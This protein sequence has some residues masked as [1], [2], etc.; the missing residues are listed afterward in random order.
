VGT[1]EAYPNRDSLSY[2][3]SFGL[4]DVRTMIRGT[5][6]YPGWSETWARLVQLGLPNENLRIPNLAERSFAE[7]V[8]MFLPL[9]ISGPK[10][11]TRVARFLGISPTGKIIE[12]MRWLGLFSN[13]PT[14]CRGDTAAAL[15][16]DMLSKKMPLGT[17][18]R[19]MVVLAHE[20]EIE[21]PES[22]RKAETLTSTMVVEGEPGGM[23]AMAKT[24]GLPA[25]LA[26]RM[27]LTGQ[28][29]L[30]GSHIPTHP[31]IYEPVLVELAS[32]GIS[33]TERVTEVG[34]AE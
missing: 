14:G 20:L 27:V 4:N 21:Y 6:R 9:N 22:D 28:L 10:L 8:E 25:A 13:E 11:D 7:V 2:M 26:A 5:L 19:D 29:H 1:L 30:A 15:L 31:S 12:N 17:D 24:V 32:E 18:G 34:P 33:F 23:T 16:I 3:Q